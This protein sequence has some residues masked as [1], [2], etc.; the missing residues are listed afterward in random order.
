[1][2]GRDWNRQN[3]LIIAEFRANHGR[4]GGY[5]ADK[6]LILLTTTGAKTGTSRVSPLGYFRDEDRYIVFASVAGEPTNPAWYYNLLAEP[7]VTVEVGD[8][9]ALARAE[10]IS[11]R[12]R[13]DLLARYVSAHPQWAQYQ[14]A[15]TR[16][17]PVVALH[18]LDRS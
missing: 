3:A 10:V 16:Q 13:Q 14:A 15:T 5:F 6:P 17:F 9:T 7:I 18:P 12:D 11:G 1:M 4:V 8:E 2:S